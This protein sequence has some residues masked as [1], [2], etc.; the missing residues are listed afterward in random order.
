MAE[1]DV[2]FLKKQRHWEGS[3]QHH[4][5]GNCRVLCFVFSHSAQNCF[6]CSCAGAS[7]GASS[8]GV[9]GCGG[10]IVIRADI[11]LGVG[12]CCCLLLHL[13]LLLHMGCLPRGE[14]LPRWSGFSYLN[15]LI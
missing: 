9:A 10:D 15:L 4:L 13:V 12:G 14:R 5:R 1:V 8:C 3:F 2:L 11:C 7:A 6:C